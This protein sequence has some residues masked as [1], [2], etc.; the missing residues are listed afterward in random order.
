MFLALVLLLA[1]PAA[2]TLYSD[3]APGPVTSHRAVRNLDCET[4]S[5]ER[6]AQTYPGRI[7]PEGAR[8]DF[9]ER[10]AV[11][12]KERLMGVQARHPRDEAILSDLQKTTAQFAGLV[13]A[14][15]PDL[16]T[17]TVAVEA[18][19]PEASAGGKI[20]FALKNALLDQGFQVTDRVPQLSPADMRVIGDSS[21]SIAYPLAC[22]IFD[23]RGGLKADESL[24][25]AVLRDSRETILHLGVCSHGRWQWLR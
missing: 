10:R 7:R 13:A 20:A 2:I 24:V 6:A 12:C 15:N 21:A 19:Y 22:R 1:L 23:E 8:E 11:V 16:F 9:I 18:Y 14:H 25:A 17:R 3:P 4:P 5:T